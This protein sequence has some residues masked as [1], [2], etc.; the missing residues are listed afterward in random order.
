MVQYTTQPH[1]TCKMAWFSIQPHPTCKAGLYAELFI[2]TLFPAFGCSAISRSFY[3]LK[4]SFSFCLTLQCLAI[5]VASSSEQAS[6]VS[7]NLLTDGPMSLEQKLENTLA[8]FIR[9]TKVLTKVSTAQFHVNTL[10][11]QLPYTNGCKYLPNRLPVSHN[12]V[13]AR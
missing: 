10:H 9:L 12:R 7:H 13:R 11:D 1:P 6:I 8:L 4:C 5:M 2:P 3:I